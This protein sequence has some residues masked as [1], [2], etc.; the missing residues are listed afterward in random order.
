MIWTKA[1][2]RCAHVCIYAH[3]LRRCRIVY[4]VG[5]SG[6]RY[7][8]L[9]AVLCRGMVNGAQVLLLQG[10]HVPGLEPPQEAVGYSPG[11]QG[12]QLKVQEYDTLSQESVSR[13][14]LV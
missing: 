7:A 9:Y 1:G 10:E 4:I 5:G 14:S 13:P 6:W 11:E 12:V 8:V 2:I 3:Y